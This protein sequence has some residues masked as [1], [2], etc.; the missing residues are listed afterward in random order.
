M[1]HGIFKYIFSN[2]TC[3]VPN[4]ASSCLIGGSSSDMSSFNPMNAIMGGGKLSFRMGTSG[5]LVHYVNVDMLSYIFIMI[6]VIIKNYY[7]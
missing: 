4:P 3:D 7:F 2:S 5:I 1:S 6:Y